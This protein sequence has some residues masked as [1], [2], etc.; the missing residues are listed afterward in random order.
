[1]GVEQYFSKKLEKAA[2]CQITIE[3]QDFS[4]ARLAGFLQ[5]SNAAVVLKPYVYLIPGKV[6]PLSADDAAPTTTRK[7]KAVVQ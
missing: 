3:Q 6:V 1:M 7:P 5:G 4:A 2:A